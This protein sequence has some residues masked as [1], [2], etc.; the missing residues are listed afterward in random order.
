MTCLTMTLGADHFKTGIAVAPVTDWKFYDTI[1][2]ERYM[3]TPQRNP[4][5]YRLTSPITYASK[6]NG[7]LL[8]VH[9]TTDDNV[10]WQNTIALVDELI[11]QNKQVQTMFYPGRTHG[12]SGGNTSLHLYSLMTNYLLANL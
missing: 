1:Y 7:K 8:I 12:I 3:D 4:E 11:A 6:F 5:G 2:T 10:H 9:G